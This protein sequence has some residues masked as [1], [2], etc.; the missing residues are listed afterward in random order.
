MFATDLPGELE[1]ITHINHTGPGT[2]PAPTGQTGKPHDLRGTEHT[3]GFAPIVG[4]I[5]A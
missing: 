4:N 1:V 5:Q 2:M 3:E